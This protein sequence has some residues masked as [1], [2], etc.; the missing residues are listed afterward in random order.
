MKKCEI[1]CINFT[2]QF[3]IP[4]STCEKHFMCTNCF[5]SIS[6][7]ISTSN[8][9]CEDCINFFSPK[10]K[11]PNDLNNKK[12]S[13]CSSSKINEMLCSSHYPCSSCID[14]IRSDAIKS[15]CFSCLKVS[16]HFCLNC[17]G[18]NGLIKMPLCK[19][20]YYCKSCLY[21]SYE[22]YESYDHDDF[23][24]EEL[25]LNCIECNLLI[26]NHN[27]TKCTLCKENIN[28]LDTV[29]AQGH[30]I[31]KKCDDII[32]DNKN[33]IQFLFCEVCKNILTNRKESKY[34]NKNSLSLEENKLE[35]SHKSQE[36]MQDRVII[37]DKEESKNMQD[38]V[39]I[40]GNNIKLQ[41]NLVAKIQNTL[42]NVSVPRNIYPQMLK[43]HGQY[44]NLLECNHPAC[45]ICFT[46]SFRFNYNDFITKL[47]NKD[48][49]SLNSYSYEIKCPR[50]DCTCR[51]C[52][53]FDKFRNTALSILAER[54]VNEFVCDY[55]GMIF[56]G[57]RIVFKVCG[58][59]CNIYGFIFGQGNCIYCGY[60]S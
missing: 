18:C 51:F 17:K 40:N 16:K 54:N 27:P 49:N 25:T 38:R 42:E 15:K 23:G 37:K 22:S 45:D 41:E 19:D 21:E 11:S 31:C 26:L 28:D 39:I 32:S 4:I 12:C 33:Y 8:E 46:E 52:Y 30:L 57:I 24:L 59:C 58:H 56:E 2:D 7:V 29:L 34:N 14:K 20:H 6:K 60:S 53:P 9:S 35:P 10:P 44:W 3:I 43:C 47:I 36:N 13:Y 50:E 1:C 48:A 5:G 55:Y